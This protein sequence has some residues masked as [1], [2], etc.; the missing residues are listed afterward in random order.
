MGT[1]SVISVDV[2]PWLLQGKLWIGV[3]IKSPRIRRKSN[4]NI[5][6]NNIVFTRTMIF[7][8]HK[9]H[10][11]ISNENRTMADVELNTEPKDAFSIDAPPDK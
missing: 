5:P 4:V 10:K 11:K 8:A 3:W 7:V 6:T 9:K 1:I 2:T